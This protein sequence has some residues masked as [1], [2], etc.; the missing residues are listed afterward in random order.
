LSFVRSCP[1]FL[2]FTAFGSFVYLF[3]F[4][5]L[6]IK[7][8]NFSKSV[9]TLTHSFWDCKN[10]H[11]FILAKTFFTFFSFFFH[12]ILKRS[13]L[14]HFIKKFKTLLTRKKCEISIL[15]KK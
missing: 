6:A 14:L 9:F 10:K 4:A 13:D 7:S 8:K 11:I 5:L 15:L 3:L 12:T 1:L 2:N